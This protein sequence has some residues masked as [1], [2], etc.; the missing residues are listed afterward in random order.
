MFILAW[1]DFVND[2]QDRVNASMDE[3]LIRKINLFVLQ[4][5]YIEPYHVDDFYT[6]FESRLTRA[7][8]VISALTK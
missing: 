3:E 6:Q 8:S 2:V 1:H 4:Q 5:F 7:K